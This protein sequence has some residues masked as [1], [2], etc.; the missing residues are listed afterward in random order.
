MKKIEYT[1]VSSD[2]YNNYLHKANKLLKKI[3]ISTKKPI[4]KITSSDI[5]Y[6]F[7]SNYDILFIFFSSNI[8]NQ[9]VKFKNLVQ[10]YKYF[11]LKKELVQRISGV[12]IPQDKKFVILINQNMPLSRIVFTI[13]HELSHLYFHNLEKNDKIFTSKF[14]GNYPKELIPYEDEA[15]IIA[16]LLFCP[17]L[18]LET[19]LN[20]GFSFNKIKV[21]TNMSKKA[22]HNR[23]LNYFHHIIGLPHKEA[24]SLVLNYKDNKSQAYLT[25]KKI[26]NKKTSQQI[27]QIN[28]SIKTSNGSI[29][30]EITCTSF[31]KQ[32]S[33]NELIFELEYAHFTK[34]FLL[35]KLVIN[36]YYNK[37]KNC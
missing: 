35:E 10:N 24:L 22:L 6:Y 18:K 20:K 33:L 23:L 11:P 29:M 21:I 15:N 37:Q 32:L 2:I 19:L 17:T 27:N 31:L 25:I 36:E 13:L 7:E 12:T 14:S 8:S 34:N 5:I 26:I 16:S 9:E 4:L 28:L 3:S 1:I 30:D